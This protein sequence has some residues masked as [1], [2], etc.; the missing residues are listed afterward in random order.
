MFVFHIA[1]IKPYL[2]KC[3]N[4]DGVTEEVVDDELDD[5]I[6]IEDV[7]E[8]VGLDHVGRSS[9]QKGKQKV[10]EDI[11]TPKS[12][13]SKKGK[14]K[15]SQSP[16]IPKSPIATPNVDAVKKGCSFRL[17]AGW[18]QSEASFQIKTLD[19]R[20]EILSTNRGSIV[21]LDVDTLDDGKTQVKRMYICFKAIKEGWISCKRV[22][23]LD[24]YFLKSTRRGEL[25][26]AIGRD[27]NNQMFLMAWAVVSIENSKNWL[28]FLSNLGSDFNLAI[29]AYLTILSDGHKK[30]LNKLKKYQRYWQ[31]VPCRQRLFKVRKM[32]K[33]FG[34]NLTCTCKRWNLPGIPC[35]HAVAGYCMLN[36]DPGKGVSSWYSKQMWVDVYSN[37]I[38]PV[39]GSSILVRST[40]PPPLHPKKRI[41]PGKPR[42]NKIKHVT[43]E[44]NQ[45]SRA[46]RYM[47]CSNC[48]EKG[49]N[50]ARCYNQKRPK[51]QQEKRKPDPSAT[52]PSS[53]DPSAADLSLA[54]PK[55]SLPE[56]LLPPK[57][58][59]R[60]R[61]SS[62]TFALP[63]EFEIGESSRK[64]RL[65]R[66]EE[67]IE[68][69][70]N[71]LDELSLDR[72]EN[73]EDNIE[74]LGKGQYKGKMPPTRTSTS[75]APAMTQAAIRQLV[76]DSITIA[77][78]AQA[79]NMELL[80][81]QIETL[82]EEKLL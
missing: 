39:G 59:G 56:E 76:T 55:F 3:L 4:E 69:I 64:T 43:K 70:L 79:A 18:M 54:Y 9:S 10:V 61:L 30:E 45:P 13:K 71:H 63:Q 80:T 28:W 12:P 15:K 25:L 47:T 74:G 27:S 32:D 8:F 75:A 60:D 50:K 65:E 53:A 31:D 51:P 49:H 41:M 48:W 19:C 11:G 16:K 24:G 81:I 62:S 34:V 17:W 82:N 1:D 68:E 72:I 78:E 26:T 67:Q 38:K 29:G 7:S 14:S 66:H 42:K 20:D 35:I 77:L 57:K 37:F 21:Q 2:I 73:M 5:E 52:D 6:E 40:N 58:H 23:G 33:R 22:I 44:V 36:Q 46:G